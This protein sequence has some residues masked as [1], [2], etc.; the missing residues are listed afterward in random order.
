MVACGFYGD[1]SKP[2]KD[3]LRAAWKDF[4]L[5][6]KEKKVTCTQRRITPG[7]AARITIVFVWWG[8]PG[9]FFPVCLGFSFIRCWGSTEVVK[10]SNSVVFTHKGYPGRI[11]SHYVAEISR[12]AAS[13]DQNTLSALP[14]KR[15]FGRWLLEQLQQGQAEFPSDPKLPYQARCMLLGSGLAGLRFKFQVGGGFPLRE[16]GARRQ[17]LA[18][19]QALD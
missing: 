12:L 3:L 13:R 1:P 9:L 17:I 2:L 15:I 11:F 7:M 6:K 14:P 19:C 5:W 10:K 18:P 8:V 16:G 4:N